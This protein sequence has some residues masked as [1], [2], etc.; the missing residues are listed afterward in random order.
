M[1]KEKT[2]LPEKSSICVP[3]R[4]AEDANKRVCK[5]IARAEKKLLVL[6]K[7]TDNVLFSPKTEETKIQEI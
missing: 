4:F 6:L 5:L 3:L 7:N 2:V 1:R